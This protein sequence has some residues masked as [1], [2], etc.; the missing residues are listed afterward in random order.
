MDTLWL[1]RPRGAASCS[2][3]VHVGVPFSKW[4]IVRNIIDLT[5]KADSCAFFKALADKMLADVQASPAAKHQ[6]PAALPPAGEA[7][8]GGAAAP[9]G[10]TAGASSS[11][12]GGAASSLLAGPARVSCRVLAGCGQLPPSPGASA[13]NMRRSF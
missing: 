6:A 11:A 1:V 3:Q 9:A 5:S 2:I 8:E 7:P 10:G 12:G 4:C 13:C